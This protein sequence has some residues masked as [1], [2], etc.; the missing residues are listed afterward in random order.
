M[1]QSWICRSDSAT[2][3]T[4]SVQ[5]TLAQ[6]LQQ[7]KQRDQNAPQ[8]SRKDPQNARKSRKQGFWLVFIHTVVASSVVVFARHRDKKYRSQKSHPRKHAGVIGFKLKPM[9]GQTHRLFSS[10]NA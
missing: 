8:T 10:H 1:H 2:P 5:S 9:E 6:H 3:P 7:T 4:C